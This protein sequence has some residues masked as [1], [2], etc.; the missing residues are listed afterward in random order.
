MYMYNVC[1][2]IYTNTH[3]YTRYTYIVFVSLLN[4]IIYIMIRISV[5][6]R[7]WRLAIDEC[8]YVVI[9]LENNILNVKLFKGPLRFLML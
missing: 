8:S 1:V 6:D 4:N 3:T 2:C 5:I 7:S 9:Y